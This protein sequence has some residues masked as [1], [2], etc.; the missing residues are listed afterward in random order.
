MPFKTCQVW[1][2]GTEPI[3]S[4]NRSGDM[5]LL[6]EQLVNNNNNNI[7]TPANWLDVLMGSRPRKKQRS[8]SDSVWRSHGA[9]LNIKPK[10]WTA[11]YLRAMR[12]INLWRHTKWYFNQSW[13]KYITDLCLSVV[14]IMQKGKKNNKRKKRGNRERECKQSTTVFKDNLVNSTHS[15]LG[16]CNSTSLILHWYHII[17]CA[18]FQYHIYLTCWGTG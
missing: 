11:C 10:D 5:R 3:N 7:C 12:F 15:G 14:H 2:S 1:S 16:E 8:Q 13:V 18:L 17:Q 4:A 6:Y 9:A